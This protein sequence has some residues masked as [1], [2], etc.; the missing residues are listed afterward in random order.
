MNFLHLDDFNAQEVSIYLKAIMFTRIDAS[1]KDWR[2]LES[3]LK[4][5]KAKLMKER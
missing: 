1:T 3:E 4:I 2:K 5:A